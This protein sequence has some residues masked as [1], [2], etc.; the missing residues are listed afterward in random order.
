[1]RA[2][3]IYT[4][5]HGAWRT[6]G[7]LALLL[8]AGS[9][10]AQGVRIAHNDLPPHASA[11][12]HL[13]G[14]GLAAARGMVPPRV[15]LQRTDD[16][17]PVGPLPLPPSLIVYNTTASNLGPGLEQ[18]DVHPGFYQWDGMRWLRFEAGVGRQTY[19]NC[20]SES[21]TVGNAWVTNNNTNFVTGMQSSPS[22]LRL[23]EGDRVFFEASGALQL[24][25]G[26]AD[27]GRYTDVEVE[28]VWVQGSGWNPAGVL[29]RT[30]VSLDTRQ[31]DPSSS[32]FFF[33][34]WV[35]T[36]SG[37]IMQ[38]SVQNWSLMAHFDVPF[39]STTASTTHYKFWI[40]TRKVRNVGTVT[41]GAPGTPLEGCLRTEVFHH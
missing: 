3:P 13:D 24:S 10:A 37:Y 32:S 1:M 26:S 4:L 34:L 31:R 29:A 5:L 39:N 12:L 21:R 30:V 27:E 33:G 7:V 36:A 28:L 38:T 16:A 23:R 40:R 11:L 19:V 35:E 20:S 15:E 9:A 25:A 6:G 8:L 18:Y 22:L 41:T 14:T 2:L 17:A